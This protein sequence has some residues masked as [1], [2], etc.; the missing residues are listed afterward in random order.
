MRDWLISLLGFV[1]AGL[2]LLAYL[3]VSRGAWQGKSLAFQLVNLFGALALVLYS[4]AL[5]A[6]ANVLLNV[7]WLVVAFIALV[8]LYR[9]KK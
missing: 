5:T 6:Y 8:Q 7:V 4:I 1:G 2:I 3:Q 9:T